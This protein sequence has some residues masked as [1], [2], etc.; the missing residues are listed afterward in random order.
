MKRSRMFL[1][2][3]ML[4]MISP[5]SAGDI[6]YIVVSKTIGLRFNRYPLWEPNGGKKIGKLNV[7]TEVELLDP[8]QCGEGLVGVRALSGTLKGETGCITSDALS[9]RPPTSDEIK[10][11]ESGPDYV[12][13]K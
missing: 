8:S 5:V 13:E 11:G 6:R 2:A 4:C 9:S 10:E 7:G 12:H 1:F 3:V